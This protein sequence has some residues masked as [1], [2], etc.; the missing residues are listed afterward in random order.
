MFLCCIFI[1]FVLIL[2]GDLNQL[3]AIYDAA[4]VAE[5]QK[6]SDKTIR[7]QLT[8]TKLSRTSLQPSS[9]TK[10]SKPSSV[11]KKLESSSSVIKPGMNI[12]KQPPS[13]PSGGGNTKI[14]LKPKSKCVF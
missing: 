5:E 9:T 3:N 4:I 14:T 10:T 11:T 13:P 12:Q 7:S 1:D 2:S 6:A 8:A